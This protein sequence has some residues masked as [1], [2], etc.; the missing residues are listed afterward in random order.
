MSYTI[1][2]SYK[3]PLIDVQNEVFPISPTFDL[4]K[5]SYIY[6]KSYVEANGDTVWDTKVVSDN[7]II[8]TRNVAESGKSVYATGGLTY[9]PYDPEVYAH[10]DVSN[11]IP[12][13]RFAKEIFP[14]ATYDSG[15]DTYSAEL[16]VETPEE[17]PFNKKDVDDTASYY[18]AISEML[19]NVTV[20][21]QTIDVDE[22]E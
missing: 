10:S 16:T 8:S 21:I 11:P 1:S 14:I 19:S 22:E 2:I 6:D 7:D 20:D 15:T 9:N 3:L 12:L 5:K 13:Y 17:N 18:T 4:S